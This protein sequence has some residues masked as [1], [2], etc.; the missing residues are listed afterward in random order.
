MDARIF[1]GTGVD[2]KKPGRKEGQSGAIPR[3]HDGKVFYRPTITF[4]KADHPDLYTFLMD[5]SR[6][7][8][9]GGL[10]I[11]EALALML[12]QKPLEK[13]VDEIL[14]IIKSGI[15]VNAQGQT[16]IKPEAQND[17]I[18]AAQQEFLS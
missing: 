2:M 7:S 18:K 1:S 13:K 11:V 6:T 16:E 5:C 9:R 14:R 12:K 3:V 17:L 10:E 8:G 15:T 4:S